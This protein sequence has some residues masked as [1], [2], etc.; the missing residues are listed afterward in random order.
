[1][2]FQIMRGDTAISPQDLHTAPFIRLEALE[3]ADDK[4][5]EAFTDLAFSIFVD[6]PPKKE[7]SNLEPCYLNILET[8][9]TYHAC[10]VTGRAC[11]RART[12]VCPTCRHHALE[13][14]LKGAT[15]CPLCH[16]AYPATYLRIVVE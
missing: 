16:A 6:H 3:D 13:V 4:E 11:L 2:D 12:L 1:D 14:E 7:E 8:G 10:T 15:H 9:A 5:K